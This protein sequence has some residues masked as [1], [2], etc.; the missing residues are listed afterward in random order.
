MTTGRPGRVVSATPRG[1]VGRPVVPPDGSQVARY[2]AT[3]ARGGGSR[4]EPTSLR[5]W[6][7]MHFLSAGQTSCPR[8]VPP[9]NRPLPT[10]T[11]SD[12]WSRPRRGR[13]AS[14]G[15]LGLACRYGRPPCRPRRQSSASATQCER[16]VHART[17]VSGTGSPRL[18][19]WSIS[20]TLRG[21]P[22]DTWNTTGWRPAAART[23]GPGP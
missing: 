1:H 17:G 18:T 6:L 23:A 7:C 9:S 22:N 11:A 5:H 16:A 20:S 21:L 13:H 14:P 2:R 8:I 19:G 3:T 15:P 10:R 4:A 12:S